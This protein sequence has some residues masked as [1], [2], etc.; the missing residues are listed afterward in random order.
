[1]HPPPP[2]LPAQACRPPLTHCFFLCVFV[3]QGEAV[4]V[5]AEG[6]DISVSILLGTVVILVGT[7]YLRGWVLTHREGYFFIFMYCMFVVQQVLRSLLLGGGIE[8]C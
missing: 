1:M 4:V 8:A 3:L 2:P 5:H 7:T 6:L